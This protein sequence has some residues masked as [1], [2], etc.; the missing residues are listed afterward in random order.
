MNLLAAGASERADGEEPRSLSNDPLE[1][2]NSLDLP[3]HVL[4]FW[5]T[6]FPR[7]GPSSGPAGGAI[8]A[9]TT[10]SG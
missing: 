5:E 10:S 9:L 3:Q 1:V 6:R 4:R 7:S 2:A 8:I